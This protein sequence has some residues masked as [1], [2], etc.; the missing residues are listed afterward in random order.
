METVKI[1]NKRN[2]SI[3]NL[4]IWYIRNVIGIAL[5]SHC[6]V[7]TYALARCHAMFPFLSVYL[8]SA[9]LTFSSFIL[10]FQRLFTF[11][12]PPPLSATPRRDLA[13]FFHSYPYSSFPFSAFHLSPPRQ[14]APFSATP[15][16]LKHKKYKKV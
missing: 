5:F 1:N 10:S 14:A 7:P 6:S 9:C 15:R 2:K 8:P 16:D 11:S 4:K 12:T 3:E 13:N